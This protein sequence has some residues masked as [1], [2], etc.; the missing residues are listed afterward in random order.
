LTGK[1]L[2]GVKILKRKNLLRTIGVLT[3]LVLA[4]MQT[5]LVYAAP[6]YIYSFASF[7]AYPYNT[8]AYMQSGRYVGCGPTTGAMILAYFQHVYSLTGLLKNPVAG[9]NEGLATA[10]EL[11]YNYMHTNAAGFGSVYDIKPGLEQ[12][13]ADR[14]YRIRVMAHGSTDQD[15]AT[16]WYNDYG[17]Y[18][19]AWTNDGFFWM[20]LGGGNWDINP[21]LF[22]DFVS[23]KLS[24]GIC[25]FL[26]VDSDG[27]G[28]GDHWVPCVGYDK[29]SHLYYY[30]NTYDTTLRS[31]TID[32]CGSS[33]AGLYS[34]S[35]VR[36]VQYAGVL[37]ALS[38]KGTNSWYWNSYT[39]ISSIAQGDVDGDGKAEIVTGGH[40]WDGSRYVAQ[41]CVYN[42]ATLAL[43]N[44]RT[45]YWT[46][47]TYI[48]SVAVGDVDGDAQVEIVTGGNYWDG[49]RNNAQLCVW[50]GATLA[51]KKVKT[52]YWTGNTNIRS[53]AIGDV[54]GD[55]KVEIVTGGYYHDGTRNNAQL[56]VWNGATLASENIRTWY[57]TSQTAV[58]SVAIGDVDGDLNVE[59][60]TGGGYN[61]G[62]RVVAQLC[63]WNGATLASENVKAWY[64]TGNT[65]VWSVAIGDADGD[66]R[67]EIVTGGYHNDGTRDNAQLCVWNG[68]NLAY[69]NAKTWYWTDDTIIYAVA[70]GDLNANGKSE[71]VTGGNYHYGTRDVAQIC[72]WE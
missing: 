67:V 17:V 55:D 34:I 65:Q 64:W 54:D 33:G 56:C 49:T 53:V 30:Y 20:N 24:Q 4:S 28:G 47:S 1:T 10:W 50:N 61:D 40:Y 57:W 3:V 36:T 51:V 25:V 13:A 29:A 45:W 71:T 7:P 72:V 46:G 42:G 32:Y 6:V 35:F 68:A 66:G 44:V 62:T 41:L 63:V 48:W 52:W 39:Y 70:V 43:E 2:R 37:S 38:L 23:A 11:H 18:G 59:I 15:P 27:D 22:C 21:D 8:A 12:Y 5:S 31:A 9:T 26:T 69:E 16:S 14:G 19:D 58:F 60:V